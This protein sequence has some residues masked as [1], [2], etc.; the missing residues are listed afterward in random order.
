MQ[1]LLLAFLCCN[2]VYCRYRLSS[3]VDT[4][5][6]INYTSLSFVVQVFFFSHAIQWSLLLVYVWSSLFELESPCTFD[7]FYCFLYYC[8]LRVAHLFPFLVLPLSFLVYSFPHTTT[9]SSVD[10]DSLFLLSLCIY[11]QR[12]Q[13]SWIGACILS[14][15]QMENG[16]QL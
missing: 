15:M 6:V 4:L 1:A 9:R 16:T 13:F 5:N 10:N 8:C 11:I 2:P 12:F 3:F 14:S 7:I